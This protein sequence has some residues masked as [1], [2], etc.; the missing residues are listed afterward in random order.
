MLAEILAEILVHRNIGSIGA[1]K[2]GL[3]FLI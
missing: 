2:F 3:R 1:Q